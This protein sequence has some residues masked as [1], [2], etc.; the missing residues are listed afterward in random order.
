MYSKKRNSIDIAQL[1][2]ETISTHDKHRISNGFCLISSEEQNCPLP[3]IHA[4]DE[5]SS[6]RCGIYPM[7]HSNRSDRGLFL[8]HHVPRC[9]R[10]DRPW[11]TCSKKCYSHMASNL[12]QLA[13]INLPFTGVVAK[14][15]AVGA[16][17]TCDRKLD[18]TILH[19]L[20]S[21]KKNYS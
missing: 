12:Q 18:T 16:L 9:G 11:T 19:S 7:D 1:H 21:Y 6:W 17:L 13:F 15:I 4:R 3:G 14:T 20:L 2:L 8:R 10:Y 5:Q